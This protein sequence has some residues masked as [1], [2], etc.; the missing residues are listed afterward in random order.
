M[1]ENS[2]II[3]VEDRDTAP[4]IPTSDK[5]LRPDPGSEICCHIT[6]GTGRNLALSIDGTSNQ[7]GDKN[8][9][10]I[11]L[12]NLILKADEDRQQTWYNSGIGTY[13]RPSWKSPKYYKKVIYHKVDLAIAWDFERTVLAAYRWLSDNYETGDCIFLFGFSRGAFQVRVLSAMIDKVGLIHKGNEMQIPF[14]YEL[15]ED[16]ESDKTTTTQVGSKER[17]SSADR[18]KKAFSRKDVKVHF[19]GAWDT[20]SSIGLARGTTMLPR[21][22]DGMRHVC[23][24]RHALALD[25]RRVKFLL[26]FAYGGSTEP[27]TNPATKRAWSWKFWNSGTQPDSSSE[28]AKT[29]PVDQHIPSKTGAT[30]LERKRPHTLEVWFAGTHS[31]IGGGNVEN[32]GMDR[33]RPPLRWMVLEAGA[34]GLRTARFDRELSSKEQIEIKES[35]TPIWWFLEL[36]PLKRLTYTR[37]KDGILNTRKPHLGSPRKIHKGQKIHSSFLL[38]ERLINGQ[39]YTPKARPLEDDPNFWET[40]RKDGLGEWL[41]QDLYEYVNELVKQFINTLHV[42][43]VDDSIILQNLRQI[44]LRADGQQAVCDNLFKSIIDTFEKSDSEY[45]LKK[46]CQLL[47]S[48]ADILS[49]S[50]DDLKQAHSVEL[51]GLIRRVTTGTD[52]QRIAED[53]VDECTTRCIFVLHGHT[54]A[55]ASVA[56]ALTPY[57]NRIASGSFDNTA[58]IWDLATGKQVGEPFRGHTDYVGSVAFSPDGR[59]VVTG[60]ADKTLRIWDLETGKQIGE[61]WQGHTHWI[62]SVAFSHDGKRV[63]SGSVDS[64][65]RIWNSETGTPVGEP[66][67]GHTSSVSSVAFLPDGKRIASGSLDKT[68]RVWDP[69]TGTQI[70]APLR[71]HAYPVRSVAFSPDGKH[72]ASGSGDGTVRIWDSETG[73]E[74]DEPFRGHTHWVWSVAFSPD[75]KRIVSGSDDKTVRMW[76]LEIGKQVA[77]KGHTDEVLSVAFSRDGK[78]VVSGAHDQTIRIWDAEMYQAT[79]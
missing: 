39:P 76:D 13:A 44:A 2:N 14:A 52:G 59:R 64:T 10:V 58:R 36:L 15:Y 67:Q 78:C 38:A 35:L 5:A 40:A 28:A 24:F 66:L 4:N 75:G 26:E 55:V 42:D 50:P 25:E 31:D 17:L 23:F 73:K 11:E 47:N 74:V 68:V 12:Y 48:T 77:F 37:R 16:P 49:E 54:D 53:F 29:E 79:T 3:T 56:T 30:K 27:P 41:E 20:V 1:A 6:D 19:V 9:N 63:V 57:G 72:I 21:T 69:E 43:M 62:L 60:S 70:A 33:S 22:V 7:F 32:I 65:V 51:R 45:E 18:F 8:T 61:P 34:V 71:G 46:K